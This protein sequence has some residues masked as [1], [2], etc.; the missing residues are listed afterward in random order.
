MKKYIVLSVNQN[1]DY[2]YFM[3]IT[4][5]TWRQAGF[6]PIVFYR[7][8]RNELSDLAF[9]S[10]NIVRVLNPIDGIRDA[11]IAQMARLYAACTDVDDGD[12]LM[13]GDVDML[14]LGNHWTPDLTK[15][16][17]YNH[18]LTGFSEIPMCYVGMP[19][20]LWRTIFELGKLDYN[21]AIKRDIEN[22]PNA[23]EDDFYKW[24]G[25]DQQIL[26]ER[27]EAYG[28]DK[29]TFI[30]RGHFNGYGAG[31]VDRGSG[32]WV[33]DQPILYDA[34]LKQQTHHNAE[35][36]NQLY[37][38]LARIWPTEDFSW[39]HEYTEQFIKLAI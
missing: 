26:T 16:T 36:I 29:I 31:R 18:D 20:S 3:P 25:C 38:L 17:V 21:Q 39:F 30:N 7:G 14:A 8:E 32:G 2:M 27:L 12:Y 19:K 9:Q 10:V 28:Y 1:V 13:L 37:A 23:R 24:W 35:K 6:E 33:L 22:Y 5:W 34:H 4:V 15:V 11:T